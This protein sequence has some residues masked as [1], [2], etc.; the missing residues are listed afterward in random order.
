MDE[1]R[2]ADTLSTSH[3]RL[4]QAYRSEKPRLLARVRA[5]GRG[6]EEAEDLVHDVYVETME[7]LPLVSSIRNLPAWITSLVTRRLIDLW[8][9]QRVRQ[10]AGERDVAE[11]TLEEIIAEA[12][13][14][15]LDGY[16]RDC[17]VDALNDALKALPPEQR[18]VIEA[19]VFDGLTFREISEATGIG[20]DTLTARKRYALR[21]LGKALQH[22]IEG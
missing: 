20:I 21:T 6:L 17:L 2:A 11:D 18:A 10:A 5:A 1:H 13:W 22:W 16:V 12:G 3:G 8:R 15:P 4:T 9:H 7:R 19:Q 14:D